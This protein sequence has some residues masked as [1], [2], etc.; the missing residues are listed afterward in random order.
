MASC[1]TTFGLA[2]VRDAS[3]NKRVTVSPLG[4]MYKVQYVVGMTSKQVLDTTGILELDC[5]QI[6][7]LWMPCQ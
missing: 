4:H 2:V 1:E 3:S 7:L 6:S 5:L